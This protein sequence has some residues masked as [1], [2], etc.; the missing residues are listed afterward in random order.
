M[1]KKSFDSIN[2][3]PFIDIMLVLLVIVLTTA[4]FIQT[5]M[6]QLDLPTASAESQEPP[7][8]ELKISIDKE[9]GV[10]FDK[11]EVPRE[12]LEE[13]LLKHDREDPVHLY[14]DKDAK[15]ENFVFLLDILKKNHYENLGIVT[16][17]E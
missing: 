8:K 5:G 2:V 14:C 9:G 3:V 15:Y 10:F 6:I 4:S 13:K 17:H 16:R 12:K 1:R 11:I 7:K